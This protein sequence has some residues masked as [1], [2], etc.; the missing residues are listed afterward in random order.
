MTAKTVQVSAADGS[1]S[2]LVVLAA[3]IGMVVVA[4]NTTAVMTLLPAMKSDFDMDRQTLQWV[5]NI[6]MLSAAVAIA[7]MGRFADIFGAMRIFGVGLGAFG[8]GSLAIAVAVDDAMILIGRAFQGLGAAGV[9][10]TSV[11]LI[12]IATPDDRRAQALGLWSA[13]V[14]FGFAVGPLIGG[15]I[16]D[17][18][19]WRGVFFADL[20]LIGIAVLLWLRVQR[21]GLA[22]H[23]GETKAR[24]DYFGIALLVVALGTLVYGLTSGD[25]AGWTSVQTVS[26]FVIAALTGAVFLFRESRAPDPLVFFSFFHHRSY[27]A[28]TIGMFLT[29]A[30]MMGILYFFNLFIQAPGTLDFTVFQAGLALLPFTLAMFA[31]SMTVPR[32]LP[33]SGF[34]WAVTVGMLVFAIG[35]LLLHDTSDQT[36]YRDLWWKLL[37]AGIGMGLVFSLLP[38]VGLLELPDESAGQGSGIINTCLFTGL[39]MGIA[40]GSIVAAEIRHAYIGPILEK[41]MPGTPDLKAVEVTL[42]HGSRSEVDQTLVQFP[43]EDA[44]QVRAAIVQVLDDAFAGVTELMMFVGLVGCVLCFLLLRRLGGKR[45]PETPRGES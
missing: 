7:A 12:T 26:L 37:I 15:L 29:G 6:Y 43:S 33:Q 45:A 34:R 4:Y 42:L 14:A 17:T 20:P 40:A 32:L 27:L 2:W 3:C 13:A 18:I 23:V 25:I 19:G 1:K 28:G 41:L 44:E 22:P 16:T 24:I 11:A 31:I 8:I 10:S 36:P 35:F 9:I 30:M 21:L 39:S 38:R 5:M